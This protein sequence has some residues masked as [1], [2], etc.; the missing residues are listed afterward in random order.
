MSSGKVT[1]LP[2]RPRVLA[3]GPDVR[4]DLVLLEVDEKTLDELLVHG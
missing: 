1:I 2:G 4:K 3:Y